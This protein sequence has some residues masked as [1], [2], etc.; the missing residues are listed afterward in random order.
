MST[1]LIIGDPH[2]RPGYDLLHANHIGHLIA[3]LRPDVVVNLGDCADM[4][5]LSS[6]DKG[7]R[8]AVGRTYR[9]D[10]AAATEFN[11]RLFQ[12]IRGKKK[13]L[14]RRVILIGNHEQR[15]DRALD[16]TP[17]LVGSIGYPDL[18]Y[19]KYYQDVVYYD[20]G[21]PGTIKL[22]GVNYAHYS[23]TGI[24]GRPIGGEHLAYSLVVKNFESFVVGHSHT[25]DYCRRNAPDG[26]PILGLG[27]G[28]SFPYHM[29]WAGAANHM[30]WRGVIIARNV[31]DGVFDPQFVSLAALKAEY[32]KSS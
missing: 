11:D 5:S 16:A 7:S 18:Q 4:E 2:A 23:L 31:T 8:G 29:D 32:A 30:Y 1:H 17:E 24:S 19:E 12:L 10:V 22:D 13:K 20:G 27:A 9:A 6:Y 14:P 26:R 15:I 3:D 21:T 25:L 28:C